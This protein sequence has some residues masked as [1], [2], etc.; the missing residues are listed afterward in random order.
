MDGTLIPVHDQKKTKKSKNYRR[1]VNVQI[2]CQA[3]DRRIV[4]GGEGVSGG[5]GSPAG[6]VGQS[7]AGQQFSRR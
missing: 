5:E 2:A 7:S 3:R 1:S 4:A 6:D